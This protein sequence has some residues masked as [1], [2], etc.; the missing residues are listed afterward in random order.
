MIYIYYRLMINDGV[1]PGEFLA[2]CKEPLDADVH[3]MDRN[4]AWVRKEFGV[5]IW[6]GEITQA[7][8]GTY[9]AFGIKEIEL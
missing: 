7:E 8:Y 4:S 6:W 9:Q 5:N 1:K 2:I 3:M